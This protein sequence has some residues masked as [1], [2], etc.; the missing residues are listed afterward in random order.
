MNE[1]SVSHQF[2]TDPF[3]YSWIHLFSMIVVKKA[4]VNCQSNT[5]KSNYFS[6]HLQTIVVKDSVSRQI[7]VDPF[8]LLLLLSVKESVNQSIIQLLLSLTPIVVMSTVGIHPVVFGFTYR[9]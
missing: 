7:N 1:D 5:G 6:I 9:L 4:N 2:N 8:S 3:S